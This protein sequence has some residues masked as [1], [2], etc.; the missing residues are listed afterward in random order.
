MSYYRPGDEVI[1]TPRGC[2]ARI[3]KALPGDK[4]I[5]EFDDKTLAPPQME[6]PET[7]LRPKPLPYGMFGLDP[8]PHGWS[9]SFPDK[10][11]VCP[12]CNTPWKE[13]WI[14]H[15]PYYDCLKCNLK[16]EDA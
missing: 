7:Y 2:G 9:E 3:L 16:K 13:T 10:D 6:V 8:G 11:K 15:D 14:G 4:Y 1:F 12:R 5:V